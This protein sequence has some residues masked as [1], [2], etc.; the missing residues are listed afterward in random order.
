MATNR[1]QII[2]WL[3]AGLS[4]GAA[5]MVKQVS[6]VLMLVPLFIIFQMPAVSSFQKYSL[7][8]FAASVFGI[9]SLSLLL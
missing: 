3:Y 6:V 2:W 7:M 4:F 5:V 1:K 9:I 8:V